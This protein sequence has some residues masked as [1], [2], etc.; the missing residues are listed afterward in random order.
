MKMAVTDSAA[1]SINRACA[2]MTSWPPVREPPD[3]VHYAA[4]SLPII[5]PFDCD[6]KCLS[7]LGMPE[8]RKGLS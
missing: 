2:T 5:P 7:Q 1:Q 8:H 4:A 6:G 3:T